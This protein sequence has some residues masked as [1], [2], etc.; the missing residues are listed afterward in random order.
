MNIVERF[1]EKKL[2]RLAW[3]RMNLMDAFMRSE[4]EKQLNRY[5]WIIKD[6]ANEIIYD[7]E[8]DGYEGLNAFPV[9][10]ESLDLITS[11]EKKTS[12][13]RKIVDKPEV[14]FKIEPQLWS[15]FP[16]ENLEKMCVLS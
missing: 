8:V 14:I 16:Y 15:I 13:K 6:S 10:I 7:S 5:R 3:K 11:A 2:R 4:T 1:V 9:I 12:K